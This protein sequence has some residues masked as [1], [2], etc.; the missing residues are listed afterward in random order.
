MLVGNHNTESR[1]SLTKGLTEIVQEP[2]ILTGLR[3][4]TC[5]L[6]AITSLDGIACSLREH[7][8]LRPNRLRPRCTRLNRDEMLAKIEAQYGPEERADNLLK[9]FL[10]R[11]EHTSKMTPLCSKRLAGILFMLR[12]GL[13]E[14]EIVV[15]RSVIWIMVGGYARRLLMTGRVIMYLWER[16]RSGEL[17]RC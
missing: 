5:P 4:R 1:N 9:H 6:Y 2:G 15:L 11:E 13:I 17:R 7:D 12:K 8:L 3:V 10:G 16:M 14:E